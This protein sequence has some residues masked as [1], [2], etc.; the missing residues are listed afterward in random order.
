[1]IKVKVTGSKSS[2][3]PGFATSTGVGPVTDVPV[4]PT[5]LANT[6]LPAVSGVAKVG[7]TLTASGG[8]WNP[9]GAT[10]AYQW[11]ANGAPI[12]GATGTSYSVPAGDV[13]KQLSVRVTGSM[14]GYTPASATSPA[15]GAVAPGTITATKKPKLTG[16]AKVSK[17][18]GLDVGKY[19]PAGAKVKIA[20]FLNGKKISGQ[21]KNSLAIKAAYLGKT[22]TAE[23]T[24]TAAGYSKLVLETKGKKVT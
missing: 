12:A 6:G 18:L 5:A 8:T 2:H 15:T 23:V 19:V 7:S 17:T 16:K 4:G 22:I 9:S 24:V 13:G 3:T 11:L 1:V 14:A 21:K 10:L 20:W